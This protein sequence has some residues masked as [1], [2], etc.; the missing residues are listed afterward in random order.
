VRGVVLFYL[1][2]RS[3]RYALA[4]ALKRAAM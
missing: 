3:N 2:L 1:G 4:M